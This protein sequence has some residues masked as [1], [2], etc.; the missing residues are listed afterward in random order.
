MR[1]RMSLDKNFAQYWQADVK[2]LDVVLGRLGDPNNSVATFVN[3]SLYDE[4]KAAIGSFQATGD[5][6][7]RLPLGSL[8]RS[9]PRHEPSAATLHARICAGGG[10]TPSS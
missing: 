3:A 4:T 5:A 2:G 9:Y 6:Q 8:R 1:N 10:P 7:R